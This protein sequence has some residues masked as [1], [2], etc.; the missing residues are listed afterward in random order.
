VRI[1]HISD[2]HLTDRLPHFQE[3]N[4]SV[5]AWL[6]SREADLVIHTGDVGMDGAGHVDDLRAGMRWAAVHGIPVLAVP[7]NHDVGDTAEIRPDQTIDDERLERWRAEVGEDR[8]TLDRDGWRLIGLNAMLMG[9]GH[10][11]EARQV[12]WF[13]GVLE[14]DGPVAVF[15]HKPL[16]VEDPSEGPR[17]YWTVRPEPRARILSL[18]EGRDVRLVGSGHLHIARHATFGETQHVWA[19]SSAFVVGGL[20]ENLEERLGGS[21]RL[22]VVVYD[23]TP[24]GVVA[25]FERP[26]GLVDHRIDD[27]IHEVYPKADPAGAR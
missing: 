20:Q 19:P 24:E 8:W 21:R 10:P 25:H 2:T 27:V 9:S 17:G 5:A 14:H 15:L 4:A 6:R 16:Y 11:E 18:M 7:G 23:F 26:A 12:D 22:G 3:N 1:V 13:A